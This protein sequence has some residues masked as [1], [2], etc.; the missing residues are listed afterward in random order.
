MLVLLAFAVAKN[1]SSALQPS[2]YVVNFKEQILQQWYLLNA[3]FRWWGL[4]ALAT[5]AAAFNAIAV[6]LSNN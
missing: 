5:A 1:T 2:T 4:V 3:N 6:T